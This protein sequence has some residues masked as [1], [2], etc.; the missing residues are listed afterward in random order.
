[1]YVDFV[2]TIVHSAGNQRNV[3]R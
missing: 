3:N 2:F 1:T